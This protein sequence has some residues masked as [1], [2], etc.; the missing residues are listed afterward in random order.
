VAH[1][2]PMFAS[3][4]RDPVAVFVSMK[5]DDGGLHSPGSGPWTLRMQTM[6]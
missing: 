5:A 1:V 3:K 6:G 2:L 4:L